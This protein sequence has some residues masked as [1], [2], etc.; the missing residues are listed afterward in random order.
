MNRNQFN[1]LIYN[2]FFTSYLVLVLL[3]SRYVKTVSL[4]TPG[5]V[6]YISAVWLTYCFIYLLPA[7]TVTRIYLFIGGRKTAECIGRRYSAGA[8]L[9]AVGTT[10]MTALLL[11]A[12]Q[13]IYGMFG[14]HVNGFVLN[15]VTT[16][17]G[18]ESMGAGTSA[19]LTFFL[20]GTDIAVL[21]IAILLF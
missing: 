15:L 3:C 8:Y 5:T 11:F 18:I 13:T 12:D 6:F 21:Q 17:G 4:D 7:F 1:R 10:T 20:F 9:L 16:A 14:F 2:F 19:N